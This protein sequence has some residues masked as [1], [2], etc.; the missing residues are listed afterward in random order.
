MTS[1]PT[2][3]RS[4]RRPTRCC[5]RPTATSD[6][7]TWKW[8]STLADF[9]PLWIREDLDLTLPADLAEAVEQSAPL[10]EAVANVDP[11][12]DVL[13]PYL[14]M[15]TEDLST[16]ALNNSAILNITQT[17]FAEFVTAGG[18]EE[19]WDEYVSQLEASGLTQNVEIYQKYY[20]EFVAEQRL[21][22][23]GVAAGPHGPPP[24]P[25][26]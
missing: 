15:S 9:G 7:S 5:R 4:T 10:E 21:S 3:P 26:R 16:I 20:D 1:A 8:T 11:V 13:P 18:I 23:S 19:G 25:R 17:K 2:S 6:P 12:E 22:R 24:R 14:K